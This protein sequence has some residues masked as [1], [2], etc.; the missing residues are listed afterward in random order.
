MSDRIKRIVLAL[1]ASMAGGAGRVKSAGV[2]LAAPGNARRLLLVCV[3]GGA[4]YELLA[5]PPLRKIAPGYLGIR[6]NQLTGATTAMRDGAVLMLPGVHELRQLSLLDQVYRPAQRPGAV[7]VDRRS[8]AG[9]RFIGALR[10]RPGAHGG[11]GAIAAARYQ[12]RGGRAGR[13]GCDL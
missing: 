11:D 9:C 1:R 4:A 8:G 13:A 5:H 7:P 6:I 2:L 10:A 12:R 3:L